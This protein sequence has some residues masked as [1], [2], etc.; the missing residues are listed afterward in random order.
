MALA[1]ALEDEENRVKVTGW[2]PLVTVVNTLK[3]ETRP[4]TERLEEE[5]TYELLK[6]LTPVK[7]HR[8]PRSTKAVGRACV[9]PWET[10][11]ITLDDRVGVAV[12]RAAYY[13]LTLPERVAEV[14]LAAEDVL[15]TARALEPRG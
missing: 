10:Y 4:G 3:Q 2:K 15:K 12:G 1:G 14:K 5:D 9:K 13:L 7:E 11:A 8:C 6:Q